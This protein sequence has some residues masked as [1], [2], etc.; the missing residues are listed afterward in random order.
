MKGSLSSTDTFLEKGLNIKK[1]SE[2]YQTPNFIK[3]VLGIGIL[4]EVEHTPKDQMSAANGEWGLMS[5]T[6]GLE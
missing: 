1:G 5:R 6:S 2:F 4:L 3:H